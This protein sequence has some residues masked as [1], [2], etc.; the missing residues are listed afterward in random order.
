MVERGWEARCNRGWREKIKLS[1]WLIQAWEGKGRGRGI[2]GGE[3]ES[4][5]S[6]RLE[7]GR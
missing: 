2:K 6:F 5:H 4:K 1:F 7:E 3:R